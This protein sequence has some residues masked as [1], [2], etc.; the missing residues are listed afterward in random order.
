VV[1]ATG[2]GA[3]GGGAVGVTVGSPVGVTVVGVAVGVS[4]QVQVGEGEVGGVAVGVVYEIG[5][6]GVGWPSRVD[7]SAE[8]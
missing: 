3:D 4:W 1:T 2:A 6:V 7:A 5:D 8:F